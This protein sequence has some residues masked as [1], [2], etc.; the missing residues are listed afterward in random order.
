M[1]YDFVFSYTTIINDKRQE[2]LP[3][4]HNISIIEILTRHLRM[5]AAI[6]VKL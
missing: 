1:E 2:Y 5:V 4:T 6:F 3:K